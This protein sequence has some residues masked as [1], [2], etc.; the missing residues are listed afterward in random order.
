M[1]LE[2]LI[3]LSLLLQP[4]KVET[5]DNNIIQFYG[6]IQEDGSYILDRDAQESMFCELPLGILRTLDPYLPEGTVDSWIKNDT[7]WQ[8]KLDHNSFGILRHHYAS[9][10]VSYKL[11]YDLWDQCLLIPNSSQSAVKFFFLG[12]SIASLHNMP[13]ELRDEHDYLDIMEQIASSILT[14]KSTNRTL[15]LSRLDVVVLERPIETL[16]DPIE[17][18][19]T[20]IQIN[21]IRYGK[22]GT[23]IPVST[24]VDMLRK[25]LSTKKI[26]SLEYL[27]I[28]IFNLVPTILVYTEDISMDQG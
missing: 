5:Q 3:E 19:Y 22:E 13:E 2:D 9:C 25:D 4:V 8:L 23:S 28:N 16:V 14:G 21:T 27:G 26:Q 1:A 20:K 15:S 17:K 11:F 12:G 24:F 7:L 18:F 6:K 10:P